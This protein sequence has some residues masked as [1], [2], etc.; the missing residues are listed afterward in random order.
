MAKQLNLVVDQG[1]DFSTNVIAYVNASTTTVLDMSNYTTGY[2]QIRKSYSSST[3]T[4][5][6]SVNVWVS[7]TSGTVGLSMNNVVTSGI[8]EGRYVYDIEIVSNDT[9]AKITRVREGMITISP[10]VT[11]V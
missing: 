5:N 10:E 8:T 1:T 7:N 2:G 9:P 3:H 4:A 6:L 11:K